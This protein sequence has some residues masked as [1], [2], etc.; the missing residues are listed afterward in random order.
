MKLIVYINFFY[1]YLLSLCSRLKFMLGVLFIV[2]CTTQGVLAHSN[3]VKS[4]PEDGQI[5]SESPAQVR[6]WFSEELETQTSNL[7]VIDSSGNQVDN[8]D[9]GAD[10]DDLEHKTLLVSLP[11]SLLNGTYTVQWT[12]VSAEDGDAKNGEFVFIVGSVTA[13]DES[14][15]QSKPGVAT[16]L[17]YGA[18]GLGVII[19]FAA[20]FIVFR[21]RSADNQET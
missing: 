1:S 12:S 9:G 4:E 19:L 21:K 20:I 18:I 3:M 10:L 17:V 15:S 6:A 11:S 16:W 13:G 7:R 5:L 14:L 2:F 8:G